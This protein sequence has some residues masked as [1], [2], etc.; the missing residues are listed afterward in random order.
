MRP[1]DLVLFDPPRSGCPAGTI[2]AAAAK[3][4]REVCVISCF[5]QTQLDD[6]EV[7]RSVGYSLR[8]MSALDMFPFTEFLE[9]VS[10]LEKEG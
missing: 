5:P 3:K 9:T 8:R 10:L 1:G 2:R 4:P 6:L 7:W